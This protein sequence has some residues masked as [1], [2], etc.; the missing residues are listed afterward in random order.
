MRKTLPI[1]YLNFLIYIELFHYMNSKSLVKFYHFLITTIYFITEMSNVIADTLEHYKKK[2]RSVPDGQPPLSKPEINDFMTAA[3]VKF[4]E[5]DV[6]L[7]YDLLQNTW[8]R[9]TRFDDFLLFVD[10]LNKTDSNSILRELFDSLDS[11]HDG[12]LQYEEV[13]SGFKSL[14]IE[15]SEEEVN[16]IFK[17]ADEN[18]NQVLEFD[19][20]ARVVGDYS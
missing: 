5:Q 12:V 16:K 14:G 3:S 20:F 18:G 7:A 8:T 11:N 6:D 15:I 1:F 2:M 10:Q 19:E 9:E 4:T 17:E 13:L